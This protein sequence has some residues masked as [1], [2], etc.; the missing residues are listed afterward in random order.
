MSLKK[1]RIKPQDWARIALLVRPT[2]VMNGHAKELTM[3]TKYPDILFN[4]SLEQ[5]RQLGARGGR[6]FA[7]NQRLRR[8]AC[9]RS[10]PESV[11]TEDDQTLETAAQAIARLDAQFPWLRG[12]EMQRARCR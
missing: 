3:T 11:A 9:P 12:A 7:R 6:A 4:K 2:H 1:R 5:C 8:L 10:V